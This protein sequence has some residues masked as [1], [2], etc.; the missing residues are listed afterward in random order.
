MFIKSELADQKIAIGYFRHSAEDKQEN[1]VSIQREKAQDYCNKH[2]IIFTGYEADEGRSG[3][4]GLKDRPGF[5]KLFEN[6]I[7]NQKAAHID[8][9]LVYDESR[10]GR[11][12]N[13][14]EAAYYTVIANQHGIRIIYFENG[15]PI[16]DEPS[17]LTYLNTAIKRYMAAEYSRQLSQKVINGCIKVS[18]QGYS[19]GGTACYGMARLMLSADKKP[20]QILKHGEHKAISNARV[21]FVPHND[22]TTETV[23]RIFNLFVVDRKSPKAIAQVLNTES[24]PAPAGGLWKPASIL[25]VLTNPIYIGTRVYNKTWGRLKK[26]TRVNPKEDWVIIPECFP[27]TITEEIFDRAQNLVHFYQ[28]RI[29]A[30]RINLIKRARRQVEQEMKRV[31]SEYHFPA[32]NLQSL[33]KKLPILYCVTQHDDCAKWFFLISQESKKYDFVFAIGIRESNN[34]CLEQRFLIPTQEL[35]TKDFYRISERDETF[36]RFSASEHEV[37][38]KILQILSANE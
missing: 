25:R 13:P 12:Q 7:E 24:I 10:W 22:E 16:E 28:P 4:L 20:M 19:A 17:L 15:E 5:Q 23:K 33:F 14:D 30:R 8:Y 31:L 32:D 2:K 21:I 6:W 3:L 27:K 26:K 35:K 9:V 37:R 38:E 34:D 29:L 36:R 18:Q 11:F 1:S